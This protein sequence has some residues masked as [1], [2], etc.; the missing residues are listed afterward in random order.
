VDNGVG[1]ALFA[2]PGVRLRPF[3]RDFSTGAFNPGGLWLAGGAGFALTGEL[4]RAALDARL[5]YDLFASGLLRGGPSA[6]YVQIIETESIVRPE[7]GRLLL[8]GFH[9]A[10]EPPTRSHRTDGDRDGDGYRD[11]IDEC[12]DDAEDFDGFRDGDG[13]PDKDNDRDGIRDRTDACPN[14]A[15]DI[16]G[17]ADDDGCPD[18]DN[19][20][21]GIEDD[22]D[23]CPDIAEDEDGFEDDDG[24]PDADNDGDGVVDDEDQ[25]PDEMETVNQR[26]DDDGC[27]DNVLAKVVGNEIFLDE[28]IY[29]RTNQSEI[30]FRS[31]VVIMKLAELLRD[32]PTY[33]TI[34]IQG[35]ADDTGAADYNKDLSVLRAKSVRL[36]LILYGVKSDRLVVEGFGEERPAV[37]DTTKQARKKN[38]RVE[39]LI[40]ARDPIGGEPP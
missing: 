20:A 31:R 12:P 26:A 16:D 8:F 4:P 14:A 21:D 6:G 3:G 33:A 18:D 37:P 36:M 35:H 30:E 32:N 13:C 15:E 27:P 28:R 22:D 2:L 38:R 39:F 7:D 9:G 34:R 10:I 19:D 29:F 25:C 1:F 11:G 5:G 40:L 17:F 23:A 24:C